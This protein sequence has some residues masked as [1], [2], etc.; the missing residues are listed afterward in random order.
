L[1]A[2]AT[3]PLVALPLVYASGPPG[4]AVRSASE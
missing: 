1:H 3:G 2:R 4:S